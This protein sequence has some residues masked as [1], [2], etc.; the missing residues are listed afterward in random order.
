MLGWGWSAKTPSWLGKLRLSRARL[1][2]Q[3]GTSVVKDYHTRSRVHVTVGAKG[4]VGRNTIFDTAR[5]YGAP[6]VPT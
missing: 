1:P 2:D 6:H 5:S 3:E 4:V